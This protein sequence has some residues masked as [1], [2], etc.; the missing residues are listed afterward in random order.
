[1][2]PLTCNNMLIASSMEIN[3]IPKLQEIKAIF[4]E[5]CHTFPI[6]PIIKG[7]YCGNPPPPKWTFDG[8]VQFISLKIPHNKVEFGWILATNFHQTNTHV[9]VSW[10]FATNFP[11]K[12]P[13]HGSLMEVCH[14]LPT[15]FPF[16]LGSGK[17][18]GNFPQTS[19]KLPIL[20]GKFFGNFPQTSH[21][22]PI[23]I[24]KFVGSLWEVC[25]KFVGSL[26]EVCGKFDHICCFSLV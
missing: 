1:M 6:V 3:N 25:G 20:I 11:Q 10:K 23:L 24:G 22:L 12:L 26:W 18:L 16:S 14:K 13:C 17:F 5:H 7:K 4:V 2:W 19:H 8:V 15:N 21:K 9:K